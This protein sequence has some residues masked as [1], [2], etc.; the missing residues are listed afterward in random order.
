MTPEELLLRVIFMCEHEE[1]TFCP[2]CL[3]KTVED[4]VAGEQERCAK[5]VKDWPG[6]YASLKRRIAAKILQP[7]KT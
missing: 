4:A 3:K 1:K 2:E 7:R 6:P 5:I